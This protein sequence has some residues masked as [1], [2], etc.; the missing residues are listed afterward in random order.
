MVVTPQR[1]E[2]VRM[3]AVIVAGLVI[4]CV[5]AFPGYMA[6]DS[7]DQLTQART[8]S[9]T[10]WHPPVMSALWG[11]LDRIVAGPLLM[12][13]LQC[14]LFLV[15]LYVLLRRRLAPT[16]AAVLT[17]VI[18]AF[19]PTLTMM[20]VVLK[21]CLMMGALLVGAAGLTSER[22]APR[23][24]G[25]VAFVLAAALR[26][27]AISMVVPL[28][29]LL[30]PWPARK[31][32][33]IRA[34]VGA[35][36]ALGLTGAGLVIN[37][38]LTDVESHPFTGMLAP[39]DIVGTLTLAPDLSDAE[40]RE[41]MPGVVFATESGLQA[42]AREVYNVFALPMNHFR[43]ERPLYREATTPE[44][45]SAVSSAWLT[46]IT[47]FPGAY[48]RWRMII[49]RELIGLTDVRWTPVYEARNEAAMLK[50]N[51]QPP[52]NRNVVQRWLAKR[53]LRLGATSLMFRPY[54]YLL[55][56]IG[57]V[58]ILRRDRMTVA[59]LL[60]GLA[61]VV[62]DVVVIP[63]PDIRYCYWLMMVTLY[64]VAVRLFVP[65]AADP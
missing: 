21:D 48:A 11:L 36:I 32:P 18:F 5:Y 28:V 2:R 56:A 40:V 45:R 17:V 9:L 53:M 30:S 55:L 52:A 44:M 49:M 37:R 50:V 23:I 41:L 62:M 16:R 57:L 8:G 58:V 4:V 39:M 19:P 64:A 61:C 1:A 26:H 31:G 47:R 51:G 3:A 54:L 20:A 46:L 10:D 34:G 38:G 6:Y 27:N 35:L 29:A 42:R 33:W 25:L 63:A 7:L 12:L 24:A 60:S 13:L 43:G 22:R 59:L 15:G 14:T 65:R